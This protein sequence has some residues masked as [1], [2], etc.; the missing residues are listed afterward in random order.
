MRRILFLILCVLAL[1]SGCT[2]P[3]YSSPGK[4][5]A[6]VEDDYTDCFSKASL[7]VNTPP[8]PD[9]PLRERDTLTD[10]CMRERGYNSHFRLF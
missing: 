8:F 5:L 10:D 9:S 1:A 7:T 3:P 2:R 6:T 4:D